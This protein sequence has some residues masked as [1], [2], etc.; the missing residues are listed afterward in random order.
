MDANL[1]GGEIQWSW[2][3]AISQRLG[4][5]HE[6]GEA[7]FWKQEIDILRGAG[8]PVDR[9]RKAAADGVVEIRLVQDSDQRLKFYEQI[10]DSGALWNLDGKANGPWAPR[11]TI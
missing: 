6:H 1:P 8:K 3:G 9:E 10:H 2:L 11:N 5:S 4:R 7:G